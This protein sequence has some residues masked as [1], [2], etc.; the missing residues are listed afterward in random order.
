MNNCNFID[1]APASLEETCLFN[2]VSELWISCVVYSQSNGDI[3]EFTFR[4]R[5]L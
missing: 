1:A 2:Q 3:F 5:L 4:F